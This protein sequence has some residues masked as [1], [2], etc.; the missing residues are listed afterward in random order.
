MIYELCNHNHEQIDTFYKVAIIQKNSLANFTHLTSISTIED[1]ITNLAS[2]SHVLIFDLLPESLNITAPTRITAT[3]E[4]YKVN[5]SMPITPQDANLQSLM[6]GY[7]NKEIV[8]ILDK[9]NTTFIYGTSH[10]PLI[11]SYDEKHSN[12]AEGLKGYTIKLDGECYGSP[13]ILE[14]VELN[15]F[16]RGL[17]FELA[18]TI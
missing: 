6:E 1:I 9:Q 5:A 15:I 2:S 16:D 18:G 12:K 3:G 11:F 8:L 7:N 14:S 13:K 17:A 4:T 10:Q